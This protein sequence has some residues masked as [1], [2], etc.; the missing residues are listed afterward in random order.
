MNAK[1]DLE[2]RLA[3]FY[4][5]EAPQRAPDWVLTAALATIETTPQRRSFIRVP[6][7]FPP[8]NG[9]PRLAAIVVAVAAV[10]AV[11]FVAMTGGGLPTPTQP[12]ATASPAIRTATP[13][14]ELMSGF[15]RP[16]TFVPLSDVPDDFG[17]ATPTFWELRVPDSARVG[18]SAWFLIVQV[19]EGGRADPCSPASASVPLADDRA[20]MDYLKTVPTL[21]VT[22][23]SETVIDGRAA[24]T[25]TIAFAEPTTACPELSF[26]ASDAEAWPF[27]RGPVT[28][29]RVMLVDIDGVTIAIHT[30]ATSQALDWFRWADDIIESIDFQD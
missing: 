13:T 25:A 12:V 18:E 8:M 5:A 29:A 30:I 1:P 6:W 11:G 17:P 9:L 15:R 27:P 16:F 26:W 10:A 23:E 7:R 22:E 24:L 21:T 28:T 2:R 20:A 19:I 3:S 14:G 4:E